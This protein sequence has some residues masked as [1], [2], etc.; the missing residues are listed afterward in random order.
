MTSFND[1]PVEIMTEIFLYLP[2]KDRLACS[3][4]CHLW[5]EA[6]NSP[7]LWRSMVIYLDSDLTEPSTMLVTRAYHEY[8]K[9]MEFCW[10]NPRLPA[11]WM[12]HDLKEFSKRACQYIMILQ[13]SYIQLNSIKIVDWYE[14]PY[15]KKIIYHL[16]KFLRSQLHLVKVSFFNTNFYKP[17]CVKLLSACLTTV[18]TIHY[19]DISNCHHPNP[20]FYDPVPMKACFDYLNSLQILKVDYTAFSSGL[21]DALLLYKNTS[22]KYIDMMVRENDYLQS[23]ISAEAWKALQV[24]CPKLKVAVHIKNRCHFDDIYHIFQETMPLTV[25]TLTC[26]KIW[27]QTRSREFRNTISLLIKNYNK[28]LERVYLQT[29]YNR[30]IL[31][32]LLITLI[33]KCANLQY[34]E[35][36]GI[37]QS[38]DLLRQVINLAKMLKASKLSSYI[39]TGNQV[40]SNN[41]KPGAPNAIIPKKPITPPVCD[42]FM[43]Q[44]PFGRV[45]LKSGPAVSAHV[46]FSHTDVKVP[47]FSDYRHA[48]LMDPHVRSS[49]SVESRQNMVYLLATTGI[50]GGIYSAKALVTDFVSSMS[51][52]ADVLALSKIEIKYSEIPEGQSVVFKWRGKPLFVRHRTPSEI[53]TERSVQ[54][55]TLRDPQ[56]DDER[57]QRSNFLVIIG[58]CTHL[59]CIPV[60]N[61]GDFGGYYCPCHGSHYDASGRIR[62]GPAPL[63]LEVPPYEFNN[64]LL[65]VG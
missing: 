58:I 52:S 21:M 26:G 39:R 49:D 30:E 45:C 47:D 60:S 11:R 35:F 5:N 8:F 62:K 31:D 25:F 7:Y 34:F 38:I 23:V 50:V 16:C 53:S 46:R 29:N 20:V 51:A 19:L 3:N 12:Q 1:L 28:I 63:N 36:H 24:Q 37:I 43:I 9:A 64:D 17:E 2:R 57:V 41:L 13:N 48:Q 18:N 61:S 22:L 6:V 33:K 65:I 55:S 14:V 10:S 4:V 44:R 32:E 42:T 15:L 40:V 27:D 59:G 56:H 54:V